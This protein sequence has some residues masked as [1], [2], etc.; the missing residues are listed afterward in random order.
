M[1]ELLPGTWE[2]VCL[3]PYW[4]DLEKLAWQREHTKSNQMDYLP[5]KHPRNLV[6]LAGEQLYE[7]HSGLP[8]NRSLGDG[9]DDGNDFEDGT[10]VKSFVFMNPDLLV[11][12]HTVNWPRHRFVMAWISVELQLG[13]LLGWVSVDVMRNAPIKRFRDDGPLT[14]HISHREL[15]PMEESVLS[16]LL[17]CQ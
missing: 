7:L 17:R 2:W 3:R 6:G 15:E 9:C 4:A 14:L 8:M 1:N 16:I 5:Q 11:R 12:A 10:D 13:A